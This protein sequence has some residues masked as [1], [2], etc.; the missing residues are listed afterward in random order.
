VLQRGVGE[1]RVHDRGGA[2]V[3]GRVPGQDGVEDRVEDAVLGQ[4]RLV[5]VVRRRVGGDHVVVGDA[6]LDRHDVRVEPVGAERGDAGGGGVVL[7]DPAAAVGPAGVDPV[8]F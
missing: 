2:G 5:R 8:V 1:L 3:G 6:G 4:V 7:A